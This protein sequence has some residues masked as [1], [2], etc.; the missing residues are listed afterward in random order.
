MLEHALAAVRAGLAVFACEPG[1]KAPLGALCPEGVYSATRDE[2]VVRR[3]WGI[4]PNANPAASPASAGCM[5]LDVDLKGGGEAALWE[6]EEKH[7]DLPRPWVVSTPGG[8]LHIWLKCEPVRNRVRHLGPGL[9]VRSAGGYV[10]LPGAVV[11]GKTYGVVSGHLAKAMATPAP[12]WLPALIGAPSTGKELV[13]EIDPAPPEVVLR[14]GEWLDGEVGG[15][16]VAVEG[17]GGDAFTLS[18]AHKLRDFGLDPEQTLDLMLDRWNEHCEPPWEP[19]DLARKVANAYRYATEPPKGLQ[20]G[21]LGAPEGALR[22]VALRHRGKYA[23]L[24]WD[25]LEHLPKPEWLVPGFLPKQGLSLV[26]GQWGS[27][28]SFFALALALSIASGRDPLQLGVRDAPGKVL[29]VAREGSVGLRMRMKA[30]VATHELPPPVGLRLV[31]AMPLLMD[32]DDLGEFLTAQPGPY[33]LV[34]LDT[35]ATATAGLDENSAQDIGRVVRTLEG[36][37]DMWRGNLMLVH[38]MDKGGKGV[39]G[40][41]VLPGAMDTIVMLSR[42]GG[43]QAEAQ[44]I[45]QKDGPDW[46][47]P[48]TFHAELVETPDGET[49]ALCAQRRG[50]VDSEREQSR[51]AEAAV[52]RKIGDRARLQ[53]A[54]IFEVAKQALESC[55]TSYGIRQLS[56]IVATELGEPADLVRERL[57]SV[58]AKGVLGAMIVQTDGKGRPT[59]FKAQS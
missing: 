29:Y 36:M 21:A 59:Y 16:R 43:K 23:G 40:S 25:D 39:R 6:L 24:G 19:E 7:G 54:R 35:Y 33:D 48:R 53:D 18:M 27:Y 55:A 32:D 9:D 12:D 3:W 10:L 57:R 44:V 46:P 22:A 37:A 47:T 11:D 50:E 49:L 4:E 52:A 38:H 56:T 51:Q 42:A 26:A 20:Q 31:P 14:A 1:G 28:K 15:G 17:E 34:V 58:A 30:F 5:V 45:K 8:G 41:T 13:S 2:A